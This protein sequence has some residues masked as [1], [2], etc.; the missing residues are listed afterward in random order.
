ME[1]ERGLSPQEAHFEEALKKYI[2]FLKKLRLQVDTAFSDEM[3]RIM[4][5]YHQRLE[6]L[7][8]IEL[9]D[10]TAHFYKELEGALNIEEEDSIIPTRENMLELIDAQLAALETTP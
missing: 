4:L 3:I 6:T 2:D 10:E 1:R 7:Q 5:I 8:E 9:Y